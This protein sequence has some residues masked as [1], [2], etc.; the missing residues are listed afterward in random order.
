MKKFI[1]YCLYAFGLPT[2]IVLIV[3]TLNELEIIHEDWRTGIGN[4]SCS[5]SDP[6]SDNSD[7]AL[8]RSN[9]S[10]WLYMYGP[11]MIFLTMNFGFYGT[12]A[13]TIYKVQEEVNAFK[14]G[15]QS[16]HTKKEKAR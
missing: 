1:Y 7:E 5:I 12:T 11:I 14:K 2:V 3:A 13:Y 6:L 10:Q 9:R 8:M 4:Y 15:E 16:R